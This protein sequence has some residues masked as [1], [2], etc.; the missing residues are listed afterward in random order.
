MTSYNDGL[1][2]PLTSAN[3][4]FIQK[5]RCTGL[6]SDVG[7]LYRKTFSPSIVSSLAELYDQF[8]NGLTHVLEKHAPIISHMAK[9]QSEEWLS[10]AY[11]MALSLR[12]H[13]EQ[14]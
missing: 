10:D 12:R 6:G 14:M 1:L 13:F 8:V 3:Y 2:N 7:F 5:P 4:N 9:Q 11:C